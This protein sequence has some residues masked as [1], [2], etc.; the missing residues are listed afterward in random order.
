MVLSCSTKVLIENT[1]QKERKG[2]KFKPKYKGPYVVSRAEGKGVYSLKSLEGKVLKNKVN[3]ARLKVYSFNMLGTG[4]HC[5]VTTFR[6]MLNEITYTQ[7][8][9]EPSHGVEKCDPSVS[10][11]DNGAVGLSSRVNS[12]L[13][14]T[15]STRIDSTMFSND[16]LEILKDDLF[17]PTLLRLWRTGALTE[18]YEAEEDMDVDVSKI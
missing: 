15:E 8:D 12:P 13:S 14:M 4:Y 7:C 10:S 2:G 11:A 9:G 6:C 1:A 3:V 16:Q 17:D 18:I 5:V